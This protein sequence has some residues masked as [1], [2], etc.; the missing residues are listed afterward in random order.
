LSY[1][2][3]CISSF[4]RSNPTLMFLRSGHALR[5]KGTDYITLRVYLFYL[6]SLQMSI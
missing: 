2:Q 3:G 4:S 6:T 5:R 1:R